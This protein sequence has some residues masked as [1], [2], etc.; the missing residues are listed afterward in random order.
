MSPRF[1]LLIDPMGKLG[2]L[3][4][5]LGVHVWNLQTM[6]VVL[7]HSLCRHHCQPVI[8]VNGLLVIVIRVG[9]W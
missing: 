6:N 9:G 5:R 2:G 4:G 3:G 7:G 1:S 8:S